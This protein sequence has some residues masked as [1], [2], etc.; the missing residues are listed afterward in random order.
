MPLTICFTCYTG[1]HSSD[2]K[3][4]LQEQGVLEAYS[5]QGDSVQEG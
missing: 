3:D 4:L 2:Q 5:A 1:E